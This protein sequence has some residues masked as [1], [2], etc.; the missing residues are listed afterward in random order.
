MDG[1]TVAASLSV[2]AN[3][4]AQFTLDGTTKS[5]T[6]LWAPTTMTAEAYAYVKLWIPSILP[7]SGMAFADPTPDV[8]NTFSQL[9][10]R[11]ATSEY[12]LARDLA[13][14]SCIPADTLAITDKLTSQS[15]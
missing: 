15:K 9:M 8:V 4:S 10:F 12:T 13:F 11:G 5:G 3:A 7:S 2:T 1:I 14:I 6:W